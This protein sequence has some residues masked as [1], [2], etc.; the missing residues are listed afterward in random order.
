MHSEKNNPLF[1]SDSYV[2][3][4]RKNPNFRRYIPYTYQWRWKCEFDEFFLVN[5]PSYL[6]KDSWI[7]KSRNYLPLDSKRTSALCLRTNFQKYFSLYL[8]ALRKYKIWRFWKFL[9]SIHK[10]II[11]CNRTPHITGKG[12]RWFFNLNVKKYPPR[13][14]RG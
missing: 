6:S 9:S 14:L 10:R 13:N 2:L 8:I 12:K 3:K 5:F 11:P 1:L 7:A 4:G